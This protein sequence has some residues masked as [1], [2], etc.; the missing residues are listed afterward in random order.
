MGKPLKPIKGGLS[1]AKNVTKASGLTAVAKRPRAPKGKLVVIARLYSRKFLQRLQIANPNADV[2]DL[3]GVLI[4]ALKRLRQKNIQAITATAW[5]GEAF[6]VMVERHKVIQ[7]L[8]KWSSGWYVRAINSRLGSLKAG[9]HILSGLFSPV[10]VKSKF[11]QP[12]RI[13]NVRLKK[14]GEQ[15]G[16]EFFDTGTLASNADGQHLP[17]NMEVKTRGAGKELPSQIGDFYDRLK[18]SPPGTKLVYTVEGQPGERQID[19][20]DLILVL[21]KQRRPL[22][23]EFLSHIG[24]IAG[25]T[26][27]V[28]TAR[29][30]QGRLYI[31]V[32][33][34][35]D[36]DAIRRTLQKLL[37]DP[38]WQ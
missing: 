17:M 34:P 15:V 31:R 16:Q 27:I 18:A 37:R 32:K 14:P 22:E 6:Q 25:K 7:D 10:T 33:L 12:V 24:V 23:E 20:K 13:N 36:T 1:I 26:P 21:D 28:K 2:K 5:L 4:L 8:M 29:D 30:A 3:R 9:I 11:N 38:S 19:I 35:I